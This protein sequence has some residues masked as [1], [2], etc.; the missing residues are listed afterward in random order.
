VTRRGCP[1]CHRCAVQCHVD[2]TLYHTLR[3]CQGGSSQI[4]TECCNRPPRKP[5]RSGGAAGGRSGQHG[6]GMRRRRRTLD[7]RQAVFAARVMRA[8]FRRIAPVPPAPRPPWP[9]WPRPA[10][11]PLRSAPQS[12]GP[13]CPITGRALK[14]SRSDP[15]TATRNTCQGETSTFRWHSAVST[16]VAPEAPC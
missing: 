2:T 6:P 14:L 3:A 12:C 7:R 11:P 8:L 13:G 16:G 15:S 9:S 4:T 1:D 5:T 10:G